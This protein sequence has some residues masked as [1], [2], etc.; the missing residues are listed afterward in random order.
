VGN[1][2]VDLEA[3]ENR[4]KS[5]DERF[6]GRIFTDEERGRLAGAARPDALLWALWAAKE[7]AYKALSRDDPG[8]P[9]IPRLYRV[10]MDDENA[11]RT[12]GAAERST[13]CFAGR[14]ITPRGVMALRID[15]TDD[16][17]HALAAGTQEALARIFHRV[18]R[19]DGR[20]GAGD[21]AAFVRMQLL[22][23]IARRLDCPVDDLA[24]RKDPAGPGAPSVLQRGRPRTA[25]ISLSH[26]GRFTA[27]ALDPA[28]LHCCKY[29]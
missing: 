25:G 8:I 19:M 18:D 1:D 9:S 5:R 10:V 29:P 21:P 7:A 2:V 15:V 20:E 27:F 22:R 11:D 6:L 3:P 26:D 16:Y 23:E 28:S 17:V 13:L 24:V 12:R 14:V 4:G